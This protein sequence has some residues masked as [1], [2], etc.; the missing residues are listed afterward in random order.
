MAS[1]IQ[2]VFDPKTNRLLIRFGIILV[3][4]V[5]AGIAIAFVAKLFN[6]NSK[7]GGGSTGNTSATNPDGTPNPLAVSEAIKKLARDLYDSSGFTV[8]CNSTRC[9]TLLAMAE[10]E[11]QQLITLGKYYKDAHGKTLQQTLDSFYVS[12]CCLQDAPDV[13]DAKLE[14]LQQKVEMLNI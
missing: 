1:A 6:Q 13:V 14:Q 4:A 9:Q 7:K 3:V 10:L 2:Q 8:L 12:G 5:V 11:N